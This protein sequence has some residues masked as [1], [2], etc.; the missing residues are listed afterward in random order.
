MY[1]LFFFGILNFN[2]LTRR[3][4]QIRIER[5]LVTKSFQE[6][7]G[8]IVPS[9]ISHYYSMYNQSFY[10]ENIKDYQVPI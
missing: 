10:Y 9:G 5:S 7:T 8:P 3:W 6:K 2:L 4:F 1:A